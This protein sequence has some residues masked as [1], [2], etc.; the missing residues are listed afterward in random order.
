MRSRRI[1]SKDLQRPYADGLGQLFGPVLSPSKLAIL[2][3]LKVKTIYAWIAAGRLD[4]C[5]RKRGKHNLIL[6]DVALERIF[7]GPSWSNEREA[8]RKD[9]NR[10]SSNDL[11]EG[12]EKDL[13]R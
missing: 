1:P 11:P 6:R 4:G 3:G 12:E 10:E 9:P 13:C 7:N 8:N 5:F 2:L